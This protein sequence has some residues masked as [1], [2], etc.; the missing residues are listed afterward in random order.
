MKD[1]YVNQLKEEDLKNLHSRIQLCI[2]Y[3]GKIVPVD[4]AI[5]TPVLRYKPENS[6]PYLT[7]FLRNFSC[8]IGKADDQVKTNIR[9]IYRDFMLEVFENTDYEVEAMV[10]DAKVKERNSKNVILKNED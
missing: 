5:Q 10:Y 3:K 4:F 6:K 2:E 1:V 8:S 9:Q 7:M